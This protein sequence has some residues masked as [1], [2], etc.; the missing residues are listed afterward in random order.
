MSDSQG[1][2]PVLAMICEPNGGDNGDLYVLR[3]PDCVCGVAVEVATSSPYTAMEMAGVVA[4][5][6]IFLGEADA[7]FS[8]EKRDKALRLLDSERFDFE[9]AAEI[10]I[11]A[12]PL[13]CLDF[14]ALGN[15]VHARWAA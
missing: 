15:W 1:S 7:R 12:E 4:T 8:Q 11:D 13:E 14:K 3:W 10:L 2:Q 6:L 5:M 9:P